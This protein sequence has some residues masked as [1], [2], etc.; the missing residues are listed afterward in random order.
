MAKSLVDKYEQIL[1]QDPAST[2]FVELARALIEKGDNP[3]AI[4]VCE[5]GLAHHVE[6]VVGRVLWG[7]ALINLGRPAE[8]ME[9]FDLAIAVDRE[10]PHAYNL[11]GEVLLHKG[12]YRSALPLLRKAVALQPNDGRVRQ[13]LEQTQV[14][15]SGGPAPILSDPTQ[16]DLQALPQQDD[17]A[18]DPTAQAPSSGPAGEP[19]REPAGEP[20]TDVFAQ[21]PSEGS[22]PAMPTVVTKARVPTPVPDATRVTKA[23]VPTPQTSPRVT[24]VM[25]P[26]Q[27]APL[28]GAEPSPQPPAPADPAAPSDDP[29]AQVV[30]RTS[31]S[32]V[33]GGLTSTFDA[34]AEGTP[35]GQG[36]ASG[37][38]EE[39]GVTVQLPIPQEP[40]VSVS[41]SL[42]EKPQ[43]G[44][45]GGLLAELPTL[46]EAPASA[47]S[48]PARASPL[49]EASARA[50]RPAGGAIPV[51]TPAGAA[52][53][54]GGGG[55][56]GFLDD[57]PE[58]PEPTS[59]LEVPKVEV[60]SQA[61]E[62]IAREY[63]RELR[64]KLAQSK[65]QKSFFA[66]HWVKLA[67]GSVAVLAVVMGA[68]VFVNIRE[69]REA[70]LRLLGEARRGIYQD[71]KE[72]LT[73]ALE[74]LGRV[75]AQHPGNADG[76]A[77]S[78]LAHA[79]LFAEQSGEGR[80]REKA[81]FHL[82]QKEV[83]A[84]HPA[85]ARVV[86]YHVA[87]AGDDKVN[88]AKALVEA[89]VSDPDLHELAGRILLEEGQA[90]AGLKRLEAALE[91]Q[92][93]HVRALVALGDHFRGTG[94][95]ARALEFYDAAKDVSPLHPARTLGAAESRLEEGEGLE[96][97]LAD[98]QALPEEASLPEA[99]RARR[100]LAE[101]RLYAAAGEA[102]KAAALLTDGLGRH[103]GHA[104]EFQIAL[105]QAHRRAGK[106]ADAE[107]ALEA[108]VKLRPGSEEAREALARVLIDRDKPREALARAPADPQS[109][110]ISMVR[111][112]AY[113]KLGFW[114]SARTELERTRVGGR[115]PTEAVIQLALADAAEGELP[116]A[117]DAL[118]KTLAVAKRARSEV[119]VALAQVHQQKGELD[120]A[121]K[122]YEEAAKENDDFEGA[123]AFGRM[124]VSLGLPDLAVEPLERAA[125]RNDSHEEAHHALAQ[126]LLMTGRAQDAA[127]RTEQWVEVTP[128]AA[129]YRMHARALLMAGQA[130]DA[131][132][133]ATQGAKKDWKS[134]EVYR[135]RAMVHFALG[136]A[137]AA[138]TDLERSNKLDAKDAETFCEIAHAFLRQGNAAHAHAAFEAALRE[139][140]EIPCG[141]VGRVYA[142]LQSGRQ[143]LDGVEAVAKSATTAWE[144]GFAQATRAKGLLALGRLKDARAA[145][146]EAVKLWPWSGVPHLVLGQVQARQKDKDAQAT[147]GRAVELD[148]AHGPARVALADVL[149]RGGPEEQAKAV[150][151]YER[152]LQI[153]GDDGD[154][155]RVKRTLPVLKKR[156]ASR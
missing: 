111:A 28:T 107:E 74:V 143:P 40:S 16:V 134:A 8:A 63:E 151:E 139:S 24:P 148:P 23:R 98:V 27:L 57:L 33:I 96:A 22:D 121:R 78:A 118:E 59:S 149:A 110:R 82:A 76:H 69:E 103:P 100:V 119:L 147:L 109:R 101:G 5:S 12:L 106:M 60:S 133:A 117:Q 51:L 94:Q 50:A 15:L 52:P 39:R 58:L 86:R 9:Q 10:D 38:K 68:W 95:H 108:A 140:A 3:R 35:R 53:S 153:G 81:L 116:R 1:A 25:T 120:L 89:E 114:K 85:I 112:S 145:A 65:A 99:L 6:S 142:K 104:F 137:K 113:A 71:T 150:D 131:L 127:A 70:T 156:V 88:R 17:P 79:V 126:A 72:S 135:T 34:L 115:Y 97:S 37:S 13:W 61:A 141:K 146:E 55:G 45:G 54:R 122:R 43:A 80:H 67:A 2:V 83:E 21:V 31:S 48:T 11:I 64:E 125:A 123:C 93:G 128:S 132:K 73:S 87:D 90:E 7:K 46:D 44:T 32:E 49:A 41:E 91:S 14:A 47:P 124:L 155:S 84:R 19:A 144:R 56:G 18:V 77:L 20:P 30:K 92:A 36:P 138:F 130:K 29:F 152:F 62:A 129:A 66:R 75:T 102:E 4:E 154:I 105:G 42:F 26:E 136:D